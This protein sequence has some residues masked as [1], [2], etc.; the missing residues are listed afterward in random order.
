M[1]SM[2]KIVSPYSTLKSRTV[3]QIRKSFPT[4]T[5]LEILLTRI[6][7]LLEYPL[8][9]YYSSEVSSVLVT[10]VRRSCTY[11]AYGQTDWRM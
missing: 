2:N 9:K 6:N 10:P 4:I 7:L 8:V 5:C 3:S 11:M 1:T